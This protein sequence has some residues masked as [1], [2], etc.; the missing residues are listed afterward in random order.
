MS[1]QE[2]HANYEDVNEVARTVVPLLGEAGVP[3]MNPTSAFPMEMDRYPGRIWVVSHKPIAVA[4]GLGQVGIHRCVIHPVFGSFINLGTILVAWRRLSPTA[5]VPVE[6]NPCVE[7]KLFAVAACPVGAIGSDGYFNFSACVTHKYR[8]FMSG[9]TD[10][11]GTIA[12]SRDRR[13][14]NSR[15]APNE[16]ASM[17]QSLSFKANYK[18]RI[19]LPSVPPGM[20]SSVHSLDDR[21]GFLEGVVDP[22][23]SKEE[24]I[25]V[26]PGSDAEDT[27]RSD[28]RGRRSDGSRAVR[29]PSGLPFRDEADFQREASKRSGGHLPP[30]VHG[31]GAGPGNGHPGPHDHRRWMGSSERPRS[32]SPRTAIPALGLVAGERRLRALLRGEIAARG[33]LRL[34]GA[35]GKC[36]PPRTGPGKGTG[37]RPRTTPGISWG[38]EPMAGCLS[39]FPAL[40]PCVK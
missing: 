18:A 11:V 37:S 15:V 9:F 24:P 22:L 26:I 3:A 29:L 1:N 35:F 31:T 23:K 2:F 17:W 33:P 12:D 5:S 30:H 14:Y 13:D 38:N 21:R 32:G 39:P 34:S 6:Y 28:S 8:E 20:M 7:C 4:A 16:S 36:F 40:N 19:A 25:Y 10:W 27:S